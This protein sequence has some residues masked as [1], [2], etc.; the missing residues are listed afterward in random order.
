M[1]MLISVSFIFDTGATYSCSS[2]KGDF[3]ELEE[4]TFP[5][6]IEGIAKGLEISGFGIVEYS[7][8][9]E[10]GSMIALWDQA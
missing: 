9:S 1:G 8:R 5:R 7:I 4:K 2:K 6:N 3:V 10:S